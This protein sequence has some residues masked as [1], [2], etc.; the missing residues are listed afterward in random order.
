[1]VFCKKWTKS[2]KNSNKIKE[3][4]IIFQ[5]IYFNNKSGSGGVGVVVWEWWWGGCNT[6]WD[7]QV[8]VVVHE[9]ARKDYTHHMI[10]HIVVVAGYPMRFDQPM[11]YE[12]LREIMV[13]GS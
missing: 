12:R 7:I 9:A 10:H 5:C 3:F 4:E 11:V 6:T 13:G 1:L 8:V 2:D